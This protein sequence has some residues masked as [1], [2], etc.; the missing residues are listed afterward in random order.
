MDPSGGSV[1]PGPNLTGEMEPGKNTNLIYEKQICSY[2]L[3]GTMIFLTF[4]L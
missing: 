3:L 4:F 1:L 2:F